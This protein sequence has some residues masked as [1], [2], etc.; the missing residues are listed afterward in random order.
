MLEQYRDAF[1]E[2]LEDVIQQ[3]D[4]EIL[5]LEQEPSSTE[6][7]Q[8]LFRAVHTLK[9][10]SAVMGYERMKQ[11]THDIEHILDQVRNQ[12]LEVSDR[13]VNLLFETIDMLKLMREEIKQHNEIR[14]DASQLMADIHRFLEQPAASGS[15]RALVKLVSIEIDAAMQVRIVEAEAKGLYVYRL[16]VKLE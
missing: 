14:I 9:G 6:H 5:L 12:R 7:V 8:V 16:N 1:I 4:E 15:S 10:S 3:M 2:E 13:L 11:L